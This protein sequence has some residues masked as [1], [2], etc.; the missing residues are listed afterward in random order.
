MTSIQI[1][2]SGVAIAGPS[3]SSI[4]NASVR[5]EDV[6]IG[7]F[8]TYMCNIYKNLFLLLCFSEMRAS[9]DRRVTD[10]AGIKE[11]KGHR[12]ID[13]KGEVRY[14]KIFFSNF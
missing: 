10:S 2:D 3:C 1:D 9:D 13:K 12:R 14:E 5:H 8:V 11:K 6:T 4:D 7:W